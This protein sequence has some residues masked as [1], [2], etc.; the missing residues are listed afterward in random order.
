MIRGRDLLASEIRRCLARR[1]V[2]NLVALGAALVVL[3]GIVAYAQFDPAELHVAD[4]PN[5][6]RLTDLW[7]PAAPDESNL[8]P[9]MV[10][11]VLG[12]IIGGALV[13][14]GEWRAGTV[15]TVAIWEVRRRRL[16][17]ARLVACGLL[18]MSFGVVLAAGFMVAILPTVIV[19]GTTSGADL[20]WWLGF[21][22][23]VAR[24]VSVAGLAAILGGALASFGRSTT[25]ALVAVFVYN[26]IG[27]QVLRAVWPGQARWLVG[28]NAVTLLTGRALEDVPFRLG[29][30]SAGITLLAYVVVLAAGSVELFARRDVLTA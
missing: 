21:L 3:A 20:G 6:A 23:A 8:L 25:G 10:V 30:V 28:E 15:V 9:A 27:E 14:G 29:P 7:R 22:G 1:A 5:I 13:V 2:R 4:N 12:A 18:A 17:A 19:H 26:A 24:G 16:L 11:L